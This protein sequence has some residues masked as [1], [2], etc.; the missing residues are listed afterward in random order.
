LLQ[1]LPIRYL[2]GI[3]LLGTALVQAQSFAAQFSRMTVEAATQLY[4][5]PD[6]SSLPIGV[7]SSGESPTPIAES[8]GAGGTKW[9]LVKTR[10]GMIGWIKQSEGDHSKKLE[11]FFQSLPRE[12]TVLAVP[13]PNASASTAPRGSSVVPVQFAGRSAIVSAMLNGMVRGNLIL[14]TGATSTVISRRL[15]A[16]L[17]IRPTGA[18]TGQ[19]VGGVITAPIARLSSV[20]LGAAEVTDITVII[21]DFSR[22]PRI[23]GLLGMDFLGQF[24]VGLDTQKQLLVLSPR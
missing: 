20:K 1:V 18:T 21:H 15:A 10:G 2:L 24:H 14:D 22:D 8:V 9:H 17:S 19:T 7:L 5:A 13:I 23:E 6:D 11:K 3:T 12:A 4:N 16:V